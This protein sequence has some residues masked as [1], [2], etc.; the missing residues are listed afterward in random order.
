MLVLG[1][2][3][4]EQD[5]LAVRTRNGEDLGAMSLDDFAA[6]VRQEIAQK[7]KTADA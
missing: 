6:K 4:A 3:E 1:D 7:G 2:R 5:M